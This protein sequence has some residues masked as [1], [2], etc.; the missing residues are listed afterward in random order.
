MMSDSFGSQWKFPKTWKTTLMK[1]I[2]SDWRGGA[3]F[4]PDD[5]TE[6]GF[7]VL[8]KGAI[9][10]S[11]AI[12]IDSKKKTFTSSEY[13]G[14]YQ[15][16]VIDRT[17]MAVTLRD[18]VPS[19]PSIGLIANLA[20]SESEKYVLAQGAYGFHV[21]KS[22]VCPSYLVWLSN[23]EPFRAYVKCY[24]V[25]STQ[26][27]IRTPVFQNLEIPLPPL[28][29]QKRIAAILDKADQVRRKRQEAIRLTEELGRSIFLDMFG[30]PVTNPKGWDVEKLEDF[31]MIQS[32]I[33][34]GKKI[35]S[36]FSI[37]IPYMRVANV[38]DGYIDLTEIKELTVSLEDSKKYSLAKGD[39]LL[40]E[41]GDPDKL[42]RGSVWYGE[43]EPCIHQNHIFCVRPN[44]DISK[45]E[46]LSKLIGSERGKKY[47][48]RAAKQTTGIATINKTQLKAFPALIPPI[49]LQE[50]YVSKL[51]SIQNVNIRF[52]QSCQE[53]ENLF[54]SLLQRAFRGEL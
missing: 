28:E 54:N 51:K 23:Y 27:H 7:P 9:H 29:E 49:K 47:F 18:L 33:A 5:F 45:P 24:A 34:K 35:K 6:E 41:G 46:F 2:S 20:N 36:D 12:L 50:E 14:R 32:G 52:S 1:N 38:Q 39:L 53:S 43:V 19:G 26:I 10:K 3:P 25:G 8:H 15:K 40:T 22:R 13:A 16:S 4:K 48:L 31:A 11:G 42:G 44:L 30:D 21:D 37:S 17:Y